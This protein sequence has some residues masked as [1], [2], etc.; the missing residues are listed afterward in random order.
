[1]P[2]AF[3]TF[4]PLLTRR[5]PDDIAL[6]AYTPTDRGACLAI[7]ADNE[8]ENKP[9]RIPPGFRSQFAQTLDRPDYLKLVL[10]RG[11]RA[12]AV[13]AIARFPRSMSFAYVWLAFGLVHPTLHGQGLGTAL[14]LARLASLPE[15]VEPTRVV[16]SN[17]IS[18]EG[19]VK[20]FGFEYQG[21]E[22]T[23]PGGDVFDVRA[24]V[25]TVEAWRRCREI[26]ADVG[27]A[28]EQLP[29]VPV[30]DLDVQTVPQDG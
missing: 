5:I 16:L 23:R 4:T 21:K 9:G 13:G 15:P 29:E 3:G 17:T 2:N 6:R 10:C 11:D 7:Y 14:M 1:M 12:A 22:G 30:M 26:I 24:A 25:L 27:I 19:F 18:S 8:A 28:L 20:R